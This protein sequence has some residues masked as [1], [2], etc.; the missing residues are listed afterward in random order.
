MN[1]LNRLHDLG[2]SVWLDNIRRE[3]LN[4]GTLAKWIAELSVAG[5][6]SN[7]TIFEH[8]ISQGSDYDAAIRA[9]AP[10]GRSPEDVFFAIALE[11]ITAAADLFR[12]AHEHSAGVDGFI[13][14]EVSPALADDTAGTIAEAERTRSIGSPTRAIRHCPPGIDS[15]TS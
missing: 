3:L 4:S 8:A 7:P 2:Q 15:T 1:A 9:Q 14:L 11:D 5:L 13:S 12:A 6:T 10:D